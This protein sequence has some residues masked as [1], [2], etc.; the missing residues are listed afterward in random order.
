M[1][2][3]PDTQI[4]AATPEVAEEVAAEVVP[5]T[6]VEEVPQEII[7]K[8]IEDTE[9]N[10][11]EINAQVQRA[12][13]AERYFRSRLKL[14]SSTE[15]AQMNQLASVQKKA[16]ELAGQYNEQADFADYLRTLIF[17]D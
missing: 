13:L 4:E 15:K 16:I 3:F 6:V 5:E 12:R 10:L 1:A 2:T 11:A 7:L 8:F 17:K 9:A 14:G